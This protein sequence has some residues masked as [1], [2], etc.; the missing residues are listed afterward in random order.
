M[1]KP[2]PRHCRQ[3][4]PFSPLSRPHLGG[5]AKVIE[6]PDGPLIGTLATGSRREPPHGNPRRQ[7]TD[8][9]LKEDLEL[10]GSGPD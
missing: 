10:S 8:Y 4:A 2:G 7:F 5:Q 3:G 9:N 1:T 6:T